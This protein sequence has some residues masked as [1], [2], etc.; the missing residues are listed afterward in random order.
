MTLL[1]RVPRHGAIAVLMAMALVALLGIA[2]LSVDYGRVALA[3]QRAQQV[4]DAAAMAAVAEEMA[5]DPAAARTRVAQVA[6]GNNEGYSEPVTCAPGAVAFFAAGQTLAG[7]TLQASEEGVTVEA[8]LA[9]PYYLAR[10]L[11][12]SGTTV[13]RRASAVRAY[14]AGSPITPMWASY[15]TNYRYGV[16][17]ELLMASDPNYA[18]IPGSFGWLTPQTGSNDFETM[19]RAYNVSPEMTDANYVRVDEIV[20]A[21]TGLSVGQWSPALDQSSDGLARLQR[22]A[23][24]PWDGDTFTSYQRSN[25]RLLIIPMCKYLGGTGSNARFQI[26]AFG[27]FWL[28]SVKATGNGSI[29]GKFINYVTPGSGTDPLAQ[30]SGLWTLRLVG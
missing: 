28:E 4:A 29:K 24:P 18:S 3:A 1:R 7:Y 17:Q 16:S 11:G 20:Y 30:F 10:V 25:P 2:A 12:L 5:P 23:L 6:E 13:V 9:V 15:L 27:V 26:M 21:Y 22:A 14:A 8:R 19:L